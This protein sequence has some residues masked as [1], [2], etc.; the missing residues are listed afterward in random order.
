MPRHTDSKPAK[1][2]QYS[3]HD[4]F[5]PPSPEARED[6]IRRLTDLYDKLNAAARQERNE[7]LL[8]WKDW[9]P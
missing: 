1:E 7:T 4:D 9:A 2:D 3:D 8:R 6:M 5:S